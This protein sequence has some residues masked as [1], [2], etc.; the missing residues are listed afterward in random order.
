M[1]S[2][3]TVAIINGPNLDRLGRRE[4][5]VYGTKTLADLEATLRTEA[6]RLGV[7]V[8]FFQSNHEGALIDHIS[9]LSEAGVAGLIINPGG[10]THTSVA[11]RDAISGSGLRAIEV[12]ISNIHSREEFRS[13][14]YTAGACL[15]VIAGLGLDGYSLA[16]RY[17][18][19]RPD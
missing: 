8:R 17:F 2:T 1:S 5:D 3:I 19:P 9:F 16:L 12:H 13:H 11:L 14:S 7:D 10:L 18:A 15:G 4:P 6:A